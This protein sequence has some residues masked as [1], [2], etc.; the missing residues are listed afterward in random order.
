MC[1]TVIMALSAVTGFVV[2]LVVPLLP[3]SHRSQLMYNAEGGRC[4]DGGMV[5]STGELNLQGKQITHTIDYSVNIPTSP[6]DKKIIPTD[7]SLIGGS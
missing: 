3:S 7:N 6:V 4:D 2:F 1:L 5:L